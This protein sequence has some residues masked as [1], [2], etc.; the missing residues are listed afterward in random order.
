ML[1]EGGGDLTAQDAQGRTVLQASSSELLVEHNVALAIL[2]L[3]RGA[4]P[5]RRDASGRTPLWLAT[6]HY[7]RYAT[8]PGTEHVTPLIQALLKAGASNL[9]DTEGVTPLDLAAR[10][11]SAPLLQLLKG[12]R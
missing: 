8:P 3:D 7:V 12:L 6:A 9:P 5:N 4:D 10:S 11:G 1:L 2:L